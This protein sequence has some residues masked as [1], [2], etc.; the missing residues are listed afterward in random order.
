MISCK[1]C[2]ANAK[3]DIESGKMLCKYCGSYFDPYEFEYE[4]ADAEEHDSG[5]VVDDRET[6]T[7]ETTVFTCPECAGEIISEENEAATFCSF[8]GASTVLASRLAKKKRPSSI[9]PFKITKEQCK[10]IYK[11]RMGKAWFAP[12]YYKDEKNIDGFRG[13]YMPYWVYNIKQQGPVTIKGEKHYRRGNYRIE[14]EYE[15]DFDL[16]AEYD[17]ISHDASSSFADNISGPLSTSST[18]HHTWEFLT[19][20]HTDALTGR[21]S[22]VFMRHHF[23]LT[24]HQ[25][26]LCFQVLLATPLNLH[27]PALRL[28]DTT[29]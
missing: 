1:N 8:C 9:I 21:G 25:N 26:F 14:E 2:G 29:L 19:T 27:S 7:Y 16:K 12:S 15:I 10:D 17:G 24:S 11:Q 18:P 3:Y 20:S 6:G 4:A 13:I 28:F 5:V 23:L 22:L